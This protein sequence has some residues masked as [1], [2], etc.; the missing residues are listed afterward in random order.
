MAVPLDPNYSVKFVNPD[1]QG[2]SL[3]LPLPEQFSF[4]VQSTWAPFSESGLIDMVTF[5]GDNAS[6]VPFAQKGAKLE[7]MRIQ[8]QNK[9]AYISS[10]SKQFWQSTSPIEFQLKFELLAFESAASEVMGKIE[11]LG[12]LALPKKG[13]VSDIRVEGVPIGGVINS[14]S[15]AIL[16]TGNNGEAILPPTRDTSLYIG[17]RIYFPSVIIT[18]ITPTFEVKPDSGGNYVMASVDVSIRTSYIPTSSDFVFSKSK[19]PEEAAASSSTL[20]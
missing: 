16:G 8:A 13:A 4:S 15:S 7:T 10:F 3:S 2:R 18:N 5:A 12:K 1:L 11:T 14:A 20:R 17:Q 9:N 6:F 19:S